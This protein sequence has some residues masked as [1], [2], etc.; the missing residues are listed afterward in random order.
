M[1][2]SIRGAVDELHSV[3]KMSD[4]SIREYFSKE[5]NIGEFRKKI[6]LI[7]GENEEKKPM[8]IQLSEKLSNSLKENSSLKLTIAELKRS[9]SKLE[10]ENAQLTIELVANGSKKASSKTV[11][12]T[13]MKGNSRNLLQQKGNLFLA[14]QSRKA[15]Q[16]LQNIDEKLSRINIGTVSLQIKRVL[17]MNAQLKAKNKE[18]VKAMELSLNICSKL[19]GI[20]SFP[21]GYDIER[22]PQILTDFLKSLSNN[23]SAPMSPSSKS[24]MS[25][26]KNDSLV[27]SIQRMNG[28][29]KIMSEQMEEEHQETMNSLQLR[30][31]PLFKSSK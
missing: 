15:N 4:Q 11:L 6:A 19:S 24:T 23:Q 17:D 7:K 25:P 14:K 22:N 9:I 29:I 5:A 28:L 1:E 13:S 8:M 27:Y 16:I 2:T 31:I 18:M 12:D 20:R 26:V 3:S 21:Q 10:A 30:E